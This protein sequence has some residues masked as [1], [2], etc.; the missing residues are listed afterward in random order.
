[1]PYYIVGRIFI[2][3]PKVPWHGNLYYVL[4]GDSSA[5][6]DCCFVFRDYGWK[7]FALWRV[8]ESSSIWPCGPSTCNLGVLN[9]PSRARHV[10]IDRHVIRAR[11]SSWCIAAWLHA[12]TTW[13][14]TFLTTHL[15]P[16]SGRSWDSN[17][18]TP[19]YPLGLPIIFFAWFL[20]RRF[21]LFDKLRQF[22]TNHRVA[23]NLPLCRCAGF[24]KRSIAS[25]ISFVLSNI[26]SRI[27]SKVLIIA[28]NGSLDSC[29]LFAFCRWLFGSFA[30][31]SACKV[32]N[33]CW[34]S[35]LLE[36]IQAL[37]SRYCHWHLCRWSPIMSTVEWSRVQKRGNY[38]SRLSI[39][40]W[41][42]STLPFHA[43][44]PN[45]SIT[46]YPKLDITFRV[47]YTSGKLHAGLRY[48]SDHT[49]YPPIIRYPLLYRIADA[50]DIR[51]RN[52][53]RL[54]K[55]KEETANGTSRGAR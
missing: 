10:A 26:S 11:L 47:Q 19:S 29:V 46:S 5:S 2:A 33:I 37:Q 30:V 32:S 4:I 22:P 20:S 12:V 9:G 44:I 27:S 24:S 51:S 55:Q 8:D 41:R 14:C 15:S 36:F 1:M 3:Y 43:I 54:R 31:Y 49:V 23:H 40:I 53:S 21:V 17:T 28:G 6:P 38:L 42:L 52:R 39:C 34:P 50:V 25:F 13:N 18:P 48:T 45:K 35:E 7:I 16:R